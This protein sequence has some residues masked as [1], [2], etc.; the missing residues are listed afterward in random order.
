M[1]EVRSL[2]QAG[3]SA[4]RRSNGNQLV[5]GGCDYGIAIL[6]FSGKLASGR[7][8]PTIEQPAVPAPI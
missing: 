2:G 8:D 6:H 5:E 4:N 3:S 7:S 1:T